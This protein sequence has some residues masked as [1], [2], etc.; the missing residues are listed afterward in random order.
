[1]LTSSAM[2]MSREDGDFT[3]AFVAWRDLMPSTAVLA[4]IILLVSAPAFAEDFVV[5]HANFTGDTVGIGPALDPVGDPDGDSIWYYS[6]TEPSSAIVHSSFWSMPNK[7]LVVSRIS[8]SHVQVYYSFDPDHIDCESY[9]V[10]FDAM[11]GNPLEYAY[12]TFR[13]E[14][15]RHFMT[16]GFADDPRLDISGQGP[17]TLANSGATTSVRWY[18][19]QAL[20]FCCGARS[21]GSSVHRRESGWDICSHGDALRWFDGCSPGC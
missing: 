21:T 14:G 6:L 20:S 17:I 4:L 2:T 3:R 11:A 7:P 18:E 8:G 15:L 16:M 12:F 5:F 19:A 10:S 9:T 13:E 1:M